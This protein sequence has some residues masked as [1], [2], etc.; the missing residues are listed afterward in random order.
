MEQKYIIVVSRRSR[1]RAVT[2]RKSS[3]EEA[4]KHVE[5]VMRAN[6]WTDAELYENDCVTPAMEDGYL[7]DSKAHYGRDGEIKWKIYK[8]RLIASRRK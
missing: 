1:R 3:I 2:I 5:S 4:R 8:L 7:L 6:L